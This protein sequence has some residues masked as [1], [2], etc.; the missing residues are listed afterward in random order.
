MLLQH[1]T[2]IL[3]CGVR[4]N[5]RLNKYLFS[6]RVS[7]SCDFDAFTDSTLVVY[8]SA[9]FDSR[10]EK[11]KNRFRSSYLSPGRVASIVAMN[12]NS[13]TAF[14]ISTS[15]I[16]ILPAVAIASARY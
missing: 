5:S 7:I 11:N 15:K 2:L 9:L 13:L 3:Y 6:T 10:R 1:L 8:A 12:L 14:D 16:A 4:I